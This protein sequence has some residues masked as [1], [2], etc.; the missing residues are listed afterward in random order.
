MYNNKYFFTKFTP[1]QHTIRVANNSSMP[2]RNTGI[3]QFIWETQDRT[4]HQV[5]LSEVL[6]IP[7][8]YINLLVYNILA[9]KVIHAIL[10][11]TSTTI[12]KN[13]VQIGYC[14]RRNGLIFFKTLS[15]MDGDIA[16]A[17]AAQVTLLELWHQ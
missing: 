5:T 11:P 8:L 12:W 6:Y 3:V 4:T 13:S 7:E 1:A 17:L 10:T 15:L 16:M 9:K 2:I 14:I